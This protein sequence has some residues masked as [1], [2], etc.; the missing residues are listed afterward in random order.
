MKRRDEVAVGVFVTIALAAVI[1]GTIWLARGGLRSGY[2]LYTQFQ[3]GQNLK[4]GHPVLL[5]GQS[6]G[7]VSDVDLK[8]GYLDVELR[9]TGDQRVPKGSVATVQ[10]VGIFGD[11][12][13]ALKPPL[14]LPVASYEPGDTVPVGPSPPDMGEILR[15][16]DSIGS[17]VSRMTAAFETELIASGGLRDLR[18]TIANTTTLS[19]QL[20]TVLAT[21]DRN[22]TVLLTDF[23]RTMAKFSNMIDSAMVDSTVKNVRTTSANMNRLIAQ[24][25]ST[26]GQIR[27]LVDKANNGRGSV[28]MLLNDTTLYTNVRNLVATMDSLLIDFK[29]DPKKYINVRITVF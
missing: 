6:I 10:P 18:R 9:I 17:S 15:R 3:W 13:V 4:K 16:V 1:A 2:P 12:A 8:P 27:L 7:Y 29:K 11:V 19:G 23:R 20:S 25:D 14:P 26:N 24:I 28:G 5:A 22:V 21:Q